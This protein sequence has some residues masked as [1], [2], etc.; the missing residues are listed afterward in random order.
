MW[1]RRYD[2]AARLAIV[3][4]IAGAHGGCSDDAG[5][6]APTTSSHDSGG[7][8]TAGAPSIGPGPM[9]ASGSDPGVTAAIDASGPADPVADAA[10]P[11][12]EAATPRDAAP[13][14]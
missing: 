2:A 1:Y 10:A 11:I 12:F 9:G 14:M 13:L 8:G 4:A 3:A 5:G 7:A 6:V